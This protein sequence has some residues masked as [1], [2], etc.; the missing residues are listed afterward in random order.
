MTMPKA[1]RGLRCAAAALAL[2]AA[3][4]AVACG[5]GDNGSDGAG[6]LLLPAITPLPTDVPLTQVPSVTGQYAISVPPDWEYLGLSDLQLD[7]FQLT[8]DELLKAEIATTCEPVYMKQDGTAWTA[9]DYI[10]RDIAL[11]IDA[12]LVE[13]GFAPEVVPAT[14]A[15]VEGLRT[16]YVAVLGNFPIRNDR[17]FVVIGQCAWILSLRIFASGEAEDYA[18][19]FTRI[20][21]TFKPT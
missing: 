14:A 20:V 15:G 13:Q 2:L 4:A 6:G 21:A 17:V 8:Q 11:L 10:D 5:S 16:Q 7:T 12:H 3:A 18:D 19:L 1:S 9:R